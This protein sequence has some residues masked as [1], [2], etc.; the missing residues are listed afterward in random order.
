MPKA[1]FIVLIR[2][3]EET[4]PEK[5]NQILNEFLSQESKNPPRKPLHP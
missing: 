2:F 1:D 5:A 3:Q 4:A